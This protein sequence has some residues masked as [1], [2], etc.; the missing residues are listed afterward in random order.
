[1]IQVEAIGADS[2][3]AGAGGV[4]LSGVR[5]VLGGSPVGEV[6]APR[7]LAAGYSTVCRPFPR[8]KSNE[9]VIFWQEVLYDTFPIYRKYIGVAGRWRA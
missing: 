2:R 1:M 8:A 6:A 5:V 7:P 3:S 4:P 9:A